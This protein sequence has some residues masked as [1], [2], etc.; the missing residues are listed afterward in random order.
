MMCSIEE[1]GSTTDMYPDAAEDGLYILPEDA[2]VGESAVSYLGLDD[3]VVEYEITSNRVD[4]FSILGIARE[5]AATFGKEFIPP[6]VTETGNTEDVNDYI[7]V[8]VEDAYL[9]P[10]YTARVVKNIKIAPSPKWMQHRLAS[11]GI[12]PINNIVD[13]TNYVMEEFG[14]PM[15]AYDMD[16]IRP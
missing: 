1:L 3:V 10:R 8:S 4:C 2:P 5:A 14:Q 6:V 12:R 13:I 15:H 9:C 11:H 16:T 7:K